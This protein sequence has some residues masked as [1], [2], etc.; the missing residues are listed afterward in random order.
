MTEDER[1]LRDGSDLISVVDVPAPAPA[2]G[3]TVTVPTLDGD[4]QVR[5]EASTQ[6]GTIVTLGRQ[7]M[8]TM[9]RG[10]TRKGDQQEVLNVVVPRT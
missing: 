2:L 9:G 8:P 6:P 5:V 4:E 7:G 10:R 3:T 1:F